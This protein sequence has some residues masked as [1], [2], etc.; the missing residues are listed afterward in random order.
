MAEQAPR[1]P[2]TTPLTASLDQRFAACREKRIWG[3]PALRRVSPW[4]CGTTVDRYPRAFK[5]MPIAGPS[6][7]T[8]G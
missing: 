5:P 6:R 4:R 8:S 1:L 3:C 2:T 7:T